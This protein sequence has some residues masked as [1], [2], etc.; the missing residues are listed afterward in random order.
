M[1]ITVG[2]AHPEKLTGPRLLELATAEPLAEQGALILGDGALDLEQELVAWVVRDRAVV[3]GDVAADAPELLK[4]EHLIGIAAGKAVGGKDADDV[5][6]AV[7]HGIAPSIETRPVEAGPSPTTSCYRGAKLLASL[8]L[9]LQIL[10]IHFDRLPGRLFDI[11]IVVTL[12]FGGELLLVP[13][14]F[15]Q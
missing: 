13:I 4:H 10:D 15:D 1:V 3:K 7:A 11:V 8:P 2:R 6:L 12:P 5:D 14:A 9:A